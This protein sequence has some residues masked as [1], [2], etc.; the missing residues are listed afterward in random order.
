MQQDQ[1]RNEEPGSDT[2]GVGGA[3]DTRKCG[4]DG[5]FIVGDLRQGGFD[6]L[7]QDVNRRNLG[8][9]IWVVRLAIGFL[10]HSLQIIE[11]RAQRVGSQC[12]RLGNIG[13]DCLF[14][15]RTFRF[16]ARKRIRRHPSALEDER[17]LSV[18]LEGV[19]QRKTWPAA[20][21][22]HGCR[23][24][25]LFGDFIPHCRALQYEQLIVDIRERPHRDWVD[26]HTGEHARRV[27][28]FVGT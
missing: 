12:T 27:T 20:R 6:S 16:V 23:I 10:E 8:C 26:A 13:V 24:P 18:A 5:F 3:V 9:Q 4:T 17:T 15:Y 28:T 1:G 7:E 11:P 2:K 25:N 14:T 22:G 21:D 19:N